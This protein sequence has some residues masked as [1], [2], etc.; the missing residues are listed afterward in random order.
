MNPFM[1]FCLYVAARVF[2]QLINKN[3]NDFQIRA[4]L[5]FVL[6]AMTVIK[7]KNPLS[8]SFLA[9]LDVD[10]AGGAADDLR[11]QTSLNIPRSMRGRW[12]ESGGEAAQCSPMVNLEDFSLQNHASLATWSANR[13]P[14]SKL[15]NTFGDKGLARHSSPNPDVAMP[16]PNTSNTSSFYSDPTL[17]D[18]R[19]NLPMRS[20][21]TPGP[22]GGT[23]M[24]LNVDVSNPYFGSY[25]IDETINE[26]VSDWTTPPE[27]L[28]SKNSSTQNS[29]PISNAYTPSDRK[30]T[31]QPPCRSSIQPPLSSNVKTN[32]AK[33]T[34]ASPESRSFLA[35]PGF[36]QQTS[37]TAPSLSGPSM[38][39]PTPG[40]EVDCSS[41]L[42]TAGDW[43][44]TST[45]GLTPGMT[46]GN[47][48]RFTSDA[49]GS[50]STA[51]TCS[52]PG[53]SNTFT[54]GDTSWL[55]MLDD[56]MTGSWEGMGANMGF[57]TPRFTGEEASD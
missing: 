55:G 54:P 19:T 35:S 6:D 33:T 53:Q 36:A 8:E 12:S 25:D 42:S 38:F 57:G 49:A 26:R 23:N 13:L 14:P 28:A 10:L 3:P 34:Y 46:P 45:T 1:A 15:K 43:D 51:T 47:M 39:P 18:G 52:M 24:I 4:A 40:N 30:D 37:P 5:K 32:Q 21:F 20:V 7:R 16:Y 9:Q 17:G 2:V 48:M 56:P 11:T 31:Q 22:P 44:G 41:F 50:G 27:S 29:F